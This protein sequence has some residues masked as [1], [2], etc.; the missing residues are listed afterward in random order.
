[1]RLNRSALLFRSRPLLDQCATA[2]AFQACW[3]FEV[4]FYAVG[5]GEQ[6]QRNPGPQERCQPDQKPRMPRIRK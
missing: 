5:A 1:M 2:K 6:R 4:A 3:L